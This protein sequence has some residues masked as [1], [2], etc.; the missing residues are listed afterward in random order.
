MGIAG[1]DELL[2]IRELALDQPGGDLGR[3][4]PEHDLALAEHDLDLSHRAR[5][6]PLHLTETLGGHQDPLPFLEHAHPLQV[7]H[8]ETVG[9]SSH[10]SK[11][12]R[13]RGEEHSRE[14]R[15]RVI[16]RRTGHDLPQRLG[17]RGCFDAHSSLGNLEEAWEL[18]RTQRSQ[19]RGEPARFDT[20]VIVGQ[21]HTD[22]AGFELVHDL[23]EQARGH[24]CTPRPLDVRRDPDPDRQL[25]I[26]T[27][28]L[29]RPVGQRNP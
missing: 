14:N 29:Q 7:A 11:T 17:E 1:G 22:R 23:R 26:G 9:V 6:E 4:H 2:I 15:T 16:A 12:P 20:R 27:H 8:G 3:S 19:R 10:E 13:R 28:E 24:D 5:Q 25:E 18:R 21:L